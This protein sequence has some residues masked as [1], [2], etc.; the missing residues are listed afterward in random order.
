[1]KHLSKKII[2][3][4][5]AMLVAVLSCACGSSEDQN[6]EASQSGGVF[7]SSVETSEYM[8]DAFGN[9][10]PDTSVVKDIETKYFVKKLT[11]KQKF[12]FCEVY[13]AVMLFKTSVQFYEPIPSEDL[14]TIMFLLNYDCPEI[15]QLA[16]DYYPE[17]TGTDLK[18]VSQVNLGYTMTSMKYKS[19]IKE[20]NSIVYQ[21]TKEVRDKSDLEKEKYFYDL[22]LG[23]CVYTEN[24]NDSA[25]VYGVLVGKEGRCEGISKA[26][27]MLL[28]KAGIECMTVSG[29][30]TW[31]SSAKYSEHSWNIVKIDGEYYNVDITTDNMEYSGLG[32]KAACYGTFNI[33]DNEAHSVR[34][35]RELYKKLGVPE[36]KSSKANYHIS[37]GT[38]IKKDQDGEKTYKELLEKHYK[39]GNKENLSVKFE[40]FEAYKI[41]KSKANSIIADYFKKDYASGVKYNTYY[42]DLSQTLVTDT[43]GGKKE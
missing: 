37:S 43:S 1:M 31:N 13:K 3:V 42:N 10:V 8:V 19:A 27:M 23:D 18:K 38:Y 33:T 35:V 32:K 28:R 41:I 11:E 20:V 26:F 7:E 2:A 30:Q 14:D 12:F 29:S 15:L 4:I 36:C 22:I 17:Y 40:S 25:N 24:T 39:D 16:G 21:K 6:G 9:N 5:S 34:A